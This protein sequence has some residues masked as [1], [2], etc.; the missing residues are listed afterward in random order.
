MKKKQDKYWDTIDAAE[1]EVNKWPDWKRA[2]GNFKSNYCHELQKE[3][4]KSK[5][6]LEFPQV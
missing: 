2:L 1:K 4:F 5:Y 6:Y 3:S